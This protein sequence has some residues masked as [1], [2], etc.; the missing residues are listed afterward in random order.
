MGNK[1]LQSANKE[2]N[3]EFYTQYSD[4]E[5]EVS[6]YHEQLANK[7]IY[8]NADNP[9]KSEFARFF[10]ENFNK[11]NLSKLLVSGFP[12]LMYYK[13][14]TKE[15]WETLVDDGDFRSEECLKLLQEADIVITNPPFSLFREYLKLLIDSDKKFLVLGN[16]NAITYKEVFSLIQ[17]NKIWLGTHSG[18][19]SFKVP[20]NSEPRP[21]RYW[22]DESGQKW[23]S[24]GNITWYTNLE[25]KKRHQFL[26]LTKQ[27]NPVDYPRYDNYDAIDVSKVQDIPCNYNGVVGVPITFLSKYNPDQFVIVKFRKGN[28]DKDLSVNGKCPYFRILVKRL[29]TTR[30]S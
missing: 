29:C 8:C 1:V 12:G 16:Q 20:D 2:K 17:N 13:D 19:M 28:D 11:L 25:H 18:D 21:T 7:V 3:D 10:Q 15:Y 24:L 26:N 6:H 23:R 27:Y 5:K 4:I 9:L 14:S 30:E 22:Q